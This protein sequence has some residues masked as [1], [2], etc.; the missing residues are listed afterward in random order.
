MAL[1]SIGQNDAPQRETLVSDATDK[2]VRYK[3]LQQEHTEDKMLGLFLIL[4]LVLALT[5][6][7][8][9]WPHSKSW[10]Y[11]PAGGLGFLLA[12]A[13]VLLFMGRI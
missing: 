2:P 9:T 12:V 13:V 1:Y 4:I 11:Y 5:G 10:G 8:P 3:N 6:T 7:M